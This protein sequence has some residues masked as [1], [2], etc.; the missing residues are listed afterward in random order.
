M[1]PQKNL[2]PGQSGQDVIALQQWL[3]QNGYYIPA[4]ATG[5]YG[6]ETKNA[7]TQFQAANGVDNSSGAGFWGPKSIAAVQKIQ[8]SGQTAQPPSSVTQ[9]QTFT[10]TQGN[11]GVAQF[12]PNTGKPLGQGQ[13]STVQQTATAPSAPVAWDAPNPKNPFGVSD[14][15]LQ[16]YGT[17]KTQKEV[18]VNNAMTSSSGSRDAYQAQQAYLTSP[19]YQADIAQ[20][21]KQ[22]QPDPTGGASATTLPGGQDLNATLLAYGLTQPQID[23]LSATQKSTLGVIADVAKQAFGTQSGITFAQALQKAQQDPN[24]IAKYSDSLKIDKEILSNGLQYAQKASDLQN[25]TYAD[26]FQAD[27]KQLAEKSASAGQAYSGFRG[28]AQDSLAKSE[29]GIVESSR[30]QMKK[31]LQDL[32]TSFESKYG[33]AATTPVSALFTDPMAASNTTISGL[34]NSQQAIP[35]QIGPGT[36]GNITGTQPVQQQNDINNLAYQYTT[37]GQYTPPSVT[38]TPSK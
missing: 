33:S 34:F 5:Y 9:G 15:Y 7:V 27:R 17:P 37:M 8:S 30:A 25:K 11:K 36:I 19:Q 35:E 23:Q 6:N 21:S 13:S 32:Q 20:S 12:D 38:N 26:Q 3:I 2:Q 29:S 31:G 28:Q 24:I 22:S 1:P 16:F 18:E 14:Q 10:D 4:G